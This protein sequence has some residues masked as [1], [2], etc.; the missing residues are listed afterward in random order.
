MKK[1]KYTIGRMERVHLPEWQLHQIPA[2]VDTGAYSCAIHCENILLETRKDG[3]QILS[4][5]LLD[6]GQP[7]YHG[8]VFQTVDFSTKKV[9]SSTGEL[10]VRFLVRT[11]VQLFGENFEADFT[12]TNRK[13]MRFPVLLG[14]KLFKNHFLV[15][16]DRK[17]LSKKYL[18]QK[19]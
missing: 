2:K 5:S 18:E 15:D 7:Q 8:K 9:K 14:R 19:S 1:P 12:L 11:I 10:Q 17:N 13:S 16:V 6:P 3:S 4:F